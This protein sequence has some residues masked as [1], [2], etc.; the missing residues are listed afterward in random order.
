MKLET[1]KICTSCSETKNISDFDKKKT[2][3]FGV[4]SR[5]K[6]CRRI[7]RQENAELIREQRQK[8][9][10]KNKSNISRKNK[11]YRESNIDIMR[12]YQRNY[13]E[14]NRSAL[15]V[16]YTQYLAN[17]ISASISHRLRT[18]IRKAIKEQYGIKA[19][20]SVELLGCTID[21]C[22]RYLELKFSGGMSWDNYGLWHI[23]HIK[24][25]ISFD[26]TDP[27]QQK[28]CFHY[29]NLQPLWAKENLLKG[30]KLI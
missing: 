29:T 18:R 26:L 19:Y 16:Y 13:R 25:C 20:S 14:K 3:K 28:I 12:E 2:G 27:E 30:S 17:N 6:A 15:R 11:E 7:Y 5:C 24:P 23:D 4:R 1:Y 21:E 9:Y 22:R 10:V 8:Y